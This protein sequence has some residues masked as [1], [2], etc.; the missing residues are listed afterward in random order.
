M[1]HVSRSPWAILSQGPGGEIGKQSVFPHFMNGD[2]REIKSPLWYI[3]ITEWY[4]PTILETA[5]VHKKYKVKN[6]KRNGNVAMRTI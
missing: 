4:I 5:F 3:Q 6:N 1:F 2:E